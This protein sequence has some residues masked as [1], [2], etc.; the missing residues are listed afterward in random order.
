MLPISTS[1]GRTRLSGLAAMLA[2]TCVTTAIPAQAQL[3]PV[4]AVRPETPTR[5]QALDMLQGARG[6]TASLSQQMR[7]LDGIVYFAD[8]GVADNQ[9]VRATTDQE[10]IIAELR[11]WA[12][13]TAN[14]DG[15]GAL[16]PVG[17]SIGAASNFI[18]VLPTGF[19]VPAPMLHASGRAGL[20]WSEA[21]D[22][23]GE[24]EFLN[25]GRVAYYFTSATGTHKGV[26][27]FDGLTIPASIEVLIPR[28][29]A[30]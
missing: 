13:L 30:V 29:G 25:D 23:Y 10:H 18:C 22:A 9:A 27:A 15:E 19:I 7:G 8:D 16:A 11:E 24:L 26:T 21:A 5:R 14:W 6:G 1:D 2:L 12:K 28:E 20:E 17:L 4:R 3:E